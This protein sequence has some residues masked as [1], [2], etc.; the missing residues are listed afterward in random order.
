MIAKSSK[1]L[2]FPFFFLSLQANVIHIMKNNTSNES[3]KDYQSIYGFKK[4]K[5]V[6]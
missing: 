6:E 1:V 2:H 4:L 5:T 3:R